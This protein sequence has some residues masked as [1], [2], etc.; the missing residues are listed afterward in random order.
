MKVTDAEKAL[1]AARKQVDAER[2]ELAAVRSRRDEARR[3][4]DR[5]QRL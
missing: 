5:V 2:R 4:L 3:E 1:A